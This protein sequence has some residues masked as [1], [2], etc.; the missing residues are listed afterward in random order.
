VVVIDHLTSATP[1]KYTQWFHFNPA[2]Q[3][4]A[5]SEGAAALI[6]NTAR[7][8]RIVPLRPAVG[9]SVEIIRGQKSPRL[10]GWITGPG[11]DLT[12]ND[13]VG[14][15]QNANEATFV[16]LLRLGDAGQEIARGS[17]TADKTGDAWEVSWTEGGKPAGFRYT[18]KEGDVRLRRIE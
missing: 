1:H 11:V 13:A 15:T 3:M 14:F 5:E 10:Q 17:V 16:T 4:K 2:L 6:P 8:L 9:Q 12:P 7:Q 18:V